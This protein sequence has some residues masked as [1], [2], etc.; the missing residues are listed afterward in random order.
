MTKPTALI[1]GVTGQDGA[2]LAQ[3]LLERGY[4]VVGSIRRSSTHNDWR[5]VEL[6]IA[7]QVQLVQMDLSEFS[8]ILYVL[9]EVRPRIV[10]NLAGQSAVAASFRQPIY[11]ADVNAL[12]VIRLL[13]A[14]RLTDPTMRLFQASTPEIFADGQASP[15][16]E[17]S[18]YGAHNPYAVAKLHAHLSC[19]MY[20]DAHAMHTSVGVLFSHESPL[21]GRD[22]VTRKITSH[23]AM[24]R[25]HIDKP[26]RLG[27]LAASRDWAHARDI[28]RGMA[29]MAEQERADTYVLAT[30]KAH[31]VRDFVELAAEVAGFSLAWE[32]EGMDE[33]AF[34]RE[35]G[36]K[37]VTIDAGLFRPIEVKALLGNAEKA[38]RELDWRPQVDF[39]G[40]VEEMVKADIDRLERNQPLL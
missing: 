34:D 36:K 20:R 31:S 11:T 17:A 38:R 12:G 4:H 1:T 27:N 13:E 33:V 21:R 18:H 6:G 25:H 26:L 3:I 39:P 10:F 29:A 23:L 9:R 35:S 5:L 16:C 14:I 2:Y 19:E 22:F 32:G 15:L 24:V 37:L 40:L 8:N 28:A 30:G 7:E